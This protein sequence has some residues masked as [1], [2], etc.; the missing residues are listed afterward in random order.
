[1]IEPYFY[2]N[3]FEL[4]SFPPWP[5]PICGRHSLA[6]KP[7]SLNQEETSESQRAHSHED[8]DPEW[9]SERFVCLL[10]CQDFRCG[11]PCT[12]AGSTSY[13]LEP[14]PDFD[15][16]EYL[17]PHFVEPAPEL[18]KIPG[19]C[20]KDVA[21]NL[22]AAFSLFWNDP[23]AALNRIRISLE[24]LLDSEKVQ[25]KAKTKKGKFQQ[26]SLHHR[27]E[28]FLPKDVS[29]RTK[30]LAVKWLG[31]EGSHQG[32]ITKVEVLE[33]L[34]LVENI[35]EIVV[36]KRPQ[37]LDRMAREIAKRKGKPQK[38]PF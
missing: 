28:K 23:S 3:K 37:Y 32:S 34:E 29:T 16:T 9:V 35:L 38:P 11:E 4:G 20:P 17:E 7:G 8:W 1:M 14:G 26:L 6:I 15:T 13:D 27:I 10:V 12:V 33:A 31:N 30:L 19:K 36:V 24:A 21:T 5:C 25:K 22:R 18:I 2:G